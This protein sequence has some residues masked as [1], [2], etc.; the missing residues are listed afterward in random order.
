MIDNSEIKEEVL[1]EIVKNYKYEEIEN[2]KLCIIEMKKRGKS[3]NQ[4]YLNQ[5]SKYF[6]VENSEMLYSVEN[7]S[8]T[9][10]TIS[11]TKKKS[12]YL[13][14]KISTILLIITNYIV[15]IFLAE[16]QSEIQSDT[17]R[18]IIGGYIGYQ[19]TNYFLKSNYSKVKDKY[20][21]FVYAIGLFLIIML[22]QTILF[23]IFTF[24]SGKY[25]I[26]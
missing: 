21:P 24:F 8:T 4:N 22:I 23:L 10:D 19:I 20:N 17:R 26:A 1:N 18:L 16:N 13:K 2:L 3:L 6:K 15:N 9:I 5:I 7:L 25:F 11:S 14:F 12:Y